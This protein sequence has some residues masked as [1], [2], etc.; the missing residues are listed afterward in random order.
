MSNTVR[1][2]HTLKVAD[3]VFLVVAILHKENPDQVDFSVQEILDKADLLLLSG[4]IRPGIQIHVRQHCVANK[5]PNP[6]NYRMLFETGKSRRRLILKSDPVHIQRSGKIFPDLKDVAPEF[7][8]LIEWAMHRYDSSDERE[9]F[10]DKLL[11]L[12][13]S[14]KHIW[15]D[16]HADEYVARLRSDWD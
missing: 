1:K 8:P 12:V 6:G 11:A 10:Y 4:K 2:V 7:I 15:A 14:G 13:G 16:E 9:S 5:A 3:E